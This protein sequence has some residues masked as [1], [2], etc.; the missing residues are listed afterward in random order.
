MTVRSNLAVQA[1]TVT[2]SLRTRFMFIMLG[3][4]VIPL[5]L[6]PL[7]AGRNASMQLEHQSVAF[8]RQVAAGVGSEIEAAIVGR[9]DDLEQ[10]VLV[11]HLLDHSE[12]EQGVLLNSLLSSERMFQEIA[13]V[14]ADGDE[15]VR[16]ARDEAVLPDHLGSRS[17]EPS[18]ERARLT[19]RS[20]FGPVGFDHEAREPLMTVAYPAVDVRNGSVSAVLI[21]SLRFKPVWALL[22]DQDMT[23]DREVFVTNAAGTVVGHRD[24][25]RVLR[26]EVYLHSDADGRLPGLDGTESVVATVDLEFGDERLTVVAEQPL[27]TALEASNDAFIVTMYV[28]AFA[29]FLGIAAIALV[30]RQVIHPIE[31]LAASAERV[32]A[33]DRTERVR[34]TRLDEIGELGRAFDHMT[35]ELQSTIDELEERVAARTFELEAAA[36][37]QRSLISRLE[38]QN[39]ELASVRDRL[40]K[41]VRSKDEFLGSVSHEL[42]TPLASVLG[43]ASEL[44]D[45]FELFDPEEREQFVALIAE[46]GEDMAHIIEDLLVAARADSDGLVVRSVPT[47]ISHSVDSVLKQVSGVVTEVEVDAGLEALADPGRL[48]QILRNLVVN[49][50]RYGGA[51]VSIDVG[52]RSGEVAIRV[53]DNGTGLPRSEW[54]SIFEPYTRSHHREGQPASVGLGLTVSRILARRMGGD[55]SYRHEGGLSVFELT[56]RSSQGDLSAA[57]VSAG[58]T[59]GDTRS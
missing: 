59:A 20:Y 13:L 17:G 12:E 19:A 56:L 58:S 47:D 33:G 27:S 30:T 28:T 29:A 14:D 25:T 6:L 46:Q 43:F 35:A 41:L 42:R 51:E 23:A 5:L 11:A 54:E 1:R 40:E 7:L 4:A 8:Q 15:V 50:R 36:M 53:R 18:F 49:A 44:R 3:L 32:A 10:L 26:E 16:V 24:P 48:R 21:A 55:L 34:T 52:E 31:Q 22:G 38:A 39:E 45:N 2:Q 9:V 37:G 57:S